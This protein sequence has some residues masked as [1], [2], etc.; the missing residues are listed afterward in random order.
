MLD[1]RVRNPF[2]YTPTF[3]I[4][5]LSYPTTD[6]FLMIVVQCPWISVR[7]YDEYCKYGNC[8]KLLVLM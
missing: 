4:T 6:P 2:W 5:K 8:M 3:G 1:V 7:L